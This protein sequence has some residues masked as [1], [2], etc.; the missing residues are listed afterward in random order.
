MRS[1]SSLVALILSAA[2]MFSACVNATDVLGHSQIS[3]PLEVV[4]FGNNLDI[5]EGKYNQFLVTTDPGYTKLR[6][7]GYH[8]SPTEH[9][10]EGAVYIYKRSRISSGE[11]SD[12]KLLHS[13]KYSDNPMSWHMID[14]G[15]DGLGEDI[16]LSASISPSGEWLA[17]GRTHAGDSHTGRRPGAVEIYRLD[18]SSDFYS[19]HST[20]PGNFAYENFGYEV[21]ITDRYLVVSDPFYNGNRENMGAVEGYKLISGRWEYQWRLTSSI[22]N[23]SSVQGNKFFGFSIEIDDK[24]NNSVVIGMPGDESHFGAA[25]VFSMDNP[26]D[27]PIRVSNPY[28][29]SGDQFGKSV[30]IS[31]NVVAVC[32][33]NYTSSNRLESGS[34][35]VFNISKGKANYID[36]YLPYNRSYYDAQSEAH[37]CSDVSVSA[38]SINKW[39]IAV[40]SADYNFR[41]GRNNRTDS[42][43]IYIYSQHWLSGLSRHRRVSPSVVP[44]SHQGIAVKMV[45]SYSGREAF[46]TMKK[47][48][49]YVGDSSPARI[50]FYPISGY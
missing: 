13:I 42:G 6:P 23:K 34:V 30:S 45:N 7:T 43:A 16:G 21:D 28:Q 32:S 48:K 17:I 22:V 10:I 12:W 44:S 5:S 20:V 19:H 50:I 2:L 49:T 26:T 46:S 9:T 40:G 47:A 31:N 27:Y 35:G 24:T 37:F 36:N 4:D 15:F 14:F 29:Q 39:D 33:P 38:S 25:Y 18:S 8:S 11:Y 41:S 1:Q 3:S